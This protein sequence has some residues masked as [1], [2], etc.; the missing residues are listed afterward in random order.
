MAGW[1]L[2]LDGCE[3]ETTPGDGDRQA[4]LRCHD[5]WG[6]KESDTTERLK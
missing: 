3:F 5:S 1:H 2:Q 4:G 6:G